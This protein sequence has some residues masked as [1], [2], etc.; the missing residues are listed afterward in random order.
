[1]SVQVV[2]I[3]AD[4]WQGLGEDA[5]RALASAA[6]IVGSARQLELLPDDLPGAREPWPSPIDP[7]LD[8]LADGAP[9]GTCVLAS[10]DPMLYGVGA[11]L[12]RRL[13]AGR[14]TVHPHPS[15]LSYAC[16]RLGWP[17]S[18]V[19]L[20]SAVG[21]PLETVARLLQPRRRI[22][23]YL[24]G[25]DGAGGLARLLCERGFG[26]SEL[27]LLEQLGGPQE[28]VVRC[29]AAEWGERPAGALYCVAVECC[30]SEGTT[31]LALVPGLPDEAYEHDGQLTKRPVRALALAALSPL[32]GELLWD[33]GAGSGSVGIEWLRAEPSARAVAVEVDPE[34]AARVR[35]NARALGVPA[36]EVREGRAPECLEGLERP[37]AVFLGGGVSRPG[38]FERC[39][40]ALPAGGRLVAHA[41]TLEGERA[42]GE[43]RAAHGG[44]LLRIELSDAEP[45]GGFTG[46]RPRRPL[47]QWSL[48]KGGAA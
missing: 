44:E 20:V 39:A 31:V 43:A 14:L 10:G 5:R 6:R 3:G 4:G 8:E 33:V 18:E 47:V 15:A 2:G 35:A 37:D 22:V 21:R 17:A 38:V 16:A 36:L 29:T 30:A 42:L 28:R 46:W 26:V 45:L 9:E 1:M 40:Q 32:P 41:V 27:A 34:R 12:A 11:T 7:L 19:S 48:R 13:G 24:A 23:V 25:V